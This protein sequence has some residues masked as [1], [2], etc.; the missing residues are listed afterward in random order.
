MDISAKKHIE[1]RVLKA[2]HD[3]LR[4]ME[5]FISSLKRIAMSISLNSSQNWWFPKSWGY[6]QIIHFNIFQHI[7]IYFT[8]MGFCI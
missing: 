3:Q 6:P 4:P 8:V 1:A 2:L 5:H 7:S